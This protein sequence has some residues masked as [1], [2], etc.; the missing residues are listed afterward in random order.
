MLF[1]SNWS[2]LSSGEG[3][4]ARFSGKGF[5]LVCR[6]SKEQHCTRVEVVSG[7]GVEVGSFARWCKDGAQRQR[8]L[9]RLIPLSLPS[10]DDQRPM[11]S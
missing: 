7:V 11:L 8:G 1:R 4:E 9:A 5:C 3:K 6:K 10:N 2:A